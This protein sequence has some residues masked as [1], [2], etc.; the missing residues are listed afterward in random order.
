MESGFKFQTCCRLPILHCDVGGRVDEY[1]AIGS[2]I[3]GIEGSAA[4]ECMKEGGDAARQ[5]SAYMLRSARATE[6]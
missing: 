6:K 1:V 2:Y 4:V 3:A 5:A